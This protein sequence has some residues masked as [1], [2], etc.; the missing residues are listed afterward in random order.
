MMCAIWASHFSGRPYMARNA[1]DG[2]V[3]EE[4]GGLKCLNT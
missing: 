4:L 1:A 3:F 2:V